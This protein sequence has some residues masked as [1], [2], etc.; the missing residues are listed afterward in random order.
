MALIGHPADLPSI[1]EGD[2]RPYGALKRP[3]ALLLLTNDV[4]SMTAASSF[5]L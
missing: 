1:F 3:I 4:Q 2:G 5:Q